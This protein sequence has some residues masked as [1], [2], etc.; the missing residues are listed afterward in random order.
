[1]A[2]IR[3]LVTDLDGTLLNG[4]KT[5]SPYTRAVFERCRAAG[6]LI[7]Y[8]TAR[9]ARVVNALA[10]PRYDFIIADNGATLADD[11]SIFYSNPLSSA[12]AMP[13]IH[14]IVEEPLIKHLTVETGTHLYTSYQGEPWEPG[15]EPIEWGWDFSKPLEGPVVKCSIEC[16]ERAV[17][18]ELVDEFPELHAYFNKNEDW[19]QLMRI[20]STKAN[21]LRTLTSKMGLTMNDVVAFGDDAN[22][23]DMLR[24][25]GI[26]VAM[27]NAVDAAKVAADDICL[28]NEEDGVARWMEVNVLARR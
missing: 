28:S 3:V 9:P 5:V 1:M 23:V 6:I 16:A 2:A 21:G 20:D 24:D 11:Q 14:R 7:A 19:V 27:A 25:C 22:D 8:A 12:C 26:G 4:K 15:W 18:D 13:L 10:L 17:V